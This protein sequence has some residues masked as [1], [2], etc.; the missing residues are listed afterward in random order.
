[1]KVFKFELVQILNKYNF[2]LRKL[3]V[4]DPQNRYCEIG[5]VQYEINVMG[6]EKSYRTNIIRRAIHSGYFFYV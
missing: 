5:I 2:D 4:P 3:Q 1:M 6:V